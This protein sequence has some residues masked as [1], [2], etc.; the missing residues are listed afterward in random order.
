MHTVELLLNQWITF[1]G[2]IT[3]KIY[4]INELIIYSD[5]IDFQFFTDH[6]SHKATSE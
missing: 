4:R 1:K 2:K 3:P 6:P 5:K